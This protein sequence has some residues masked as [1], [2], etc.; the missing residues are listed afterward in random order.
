MML[1]EALRQ[2][3]LNQFTDQDVTRHTGLSERKWRELIRDHLV[4]TVTHRPGR[5]RVRLCDRNTL[6]RAAVIAALNQAGW[7]LTVSAGIALFLPFHTA[8][9]ELCDPLAILFER[10]PDVK[11]GPLPPRVQKPKVDWFDPAEPARAEPETDWSVTIYAGRF[12]GAA[13]KKR[14]TPTIFGDLR[15][16]GSRFVSWL[17]LHRKE[18]FLD[19]GIDKLARELGVKNLADAVV[20]WEDPVRWS[21]ELNR[22]GYLYEE[23]SS[24]DDPLRKV[25]KATIESPLFTTT[26]NVSLAIRKTLRRYLGIEPIELI[27]EK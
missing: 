2:Y 12:V 16:G 4:R 17:P 15:D 3:R 7:S 20:V 6:K 14:E 13:Y 5:G 8:L 23:R 18:A 24:E 21:R 9:Y 19:C 1:D 11:L 26:I 25:A 27:T 22:L 10:V